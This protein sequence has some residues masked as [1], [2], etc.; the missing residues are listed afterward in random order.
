MLRPSALDVALSHPSPLIRGGGLLLVFVGLGFL[1][2]WIFPSRW[3]PLATQGGWWYRGEYTVEPHPGGTLLTHRV[4]NVA[5]RLRWAVPPA[6]RFFAG[7][8]RRTR[9]GFGA[10]LR[11]IGREPGCGTRLL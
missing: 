8:G 11:R 2:G 4:L 7:F 9:D 5:S 1:L 6:N 3:I 10:T